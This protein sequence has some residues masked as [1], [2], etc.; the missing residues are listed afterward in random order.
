MRT[1][2]GA[3]P[4]TAT[5]DS[6]GE[7]LHAPPLCP[8]STRREIGV[9]EARS[10]LRSMPSFSCQTM[11]TTV[12]RGT[13]EWAGTDCVFPPPE[14]AA[15]KPASA[16][17]TRARTILTVSKYASTSRQ[18]PERRKQDAGASRC[19]SHAKVAGLVSL[20][21][22]ERSASF[23]CLAPLHGPEPRV[24][25]RRPA[26]S[27]WAARPTHAGNR[28]LQDRRSGWLEAHRPSSQASVDPHAGRSARLRAT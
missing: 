13:L 3:P 25:L 24:A 15:A 20:G 7:K 11:P 19:A 27:V 14:Q 9:S 16:S 4:A 23:P 2:S 21:E 18:G 22:H 5:F 6:S 28:R 10:N 1:S 26:S 8:S 17:A 12:P